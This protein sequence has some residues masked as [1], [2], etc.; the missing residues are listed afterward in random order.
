MSECQSSIVSN[1]RTEVYIPLQWM[2]PQVFQGRGRFASI[3][4][5]PTPARHSPQ[6]QEQAGLLLPTGKDGSSLSP[7]VDDC[8]RR[9]GRNRRQRNK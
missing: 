1:C 9:K 3:E 4:P 6:A 5:L 8:R 2:K 7:G